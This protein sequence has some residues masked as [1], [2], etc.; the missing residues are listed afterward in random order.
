MYI[1]IFELTIFVVFGL[2]C[3]TVYSVVIANPNPKI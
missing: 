3:I 1:D 2:V